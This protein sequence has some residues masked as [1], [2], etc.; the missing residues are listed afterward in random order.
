[1]EIILAKLWQIFLAIWNWLTFSADNEVTAG[2]VALAWGYLG[3]RAKPVLALLFFI[4]KAFKDKLL[5]DTEA[6]AL[7]WNLAAVLYGFLPSV[8]KESILRYAPAHWHP[9]IIKGE[10]PDFELIAV[11]KAKVGSVQALLTGETI[12]NPQP[13]GA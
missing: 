9:V 10:Q 7:L 5:T 11:P 4:V 1:M 2:L 13:G 8:H 3:V 6:A 12:A